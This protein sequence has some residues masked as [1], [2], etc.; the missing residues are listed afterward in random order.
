MKKIFLSIIAIAFIL[1]TQAQDA[2]ESSIELL[3][4]VHPCVEASYSRPT[5]LMEEALKKRL[6]DAKIGNGDKK[7]GYRKYEGVIIPEISADKIDLYTIVDGKKENSTVYILV[8][9]GYDNFVD[10][11]TDE[12]TI[13][14]M[15][16]FLNS[17]EV[18]AASLKLLADIEVSNEALKKAEYNYVEAVN[19]GKDLVKQKEKIE[20][21]IEENKGSQSIK[22]EEVEKAKAILNALKAKLK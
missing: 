17:L 16:K 21:N 9:K 13:M 12:T 4:A 2:K 7:K 18:S 1:N 19:E 11:K 14:N 15:K 10:S 20:K 3:K 8:S 6:T 5:D 22:S